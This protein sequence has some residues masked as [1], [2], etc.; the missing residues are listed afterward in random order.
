MLRMVFFFLCMKTTCLSSVCVE[1]NCFVMFV[2][3]NIEM[4]FTSLHLL[5]LTACSVDVLLLPSCGLFGLSIGVHCWVECHILT[6]F[7]LSSM[8]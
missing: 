3:A 5:Q 1:P 6:R 8:T 4:V 2:T 7:S